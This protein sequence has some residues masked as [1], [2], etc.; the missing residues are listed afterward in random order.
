MMEIVRMMQCLERT[1]LVLVL[2]IIGV[3]LGA[4]ALGWR[5]G[6]LALLVG[7]L[8]LT[9]QRLSRGERVIN[10]SIDT[11]YQLLGG[12]SSNREN[13]SDPVGRLRDVLEEKVGAAEQMSVL[14][15]DLMMTTGTLVSGFTEALATADSQS[16]LASSSRNEIEAM[17]ECAQMTSSEA[18]M[19]AASSTDT[20]EQVR[21]GGG[22]V[23][24]VAS[25]MVN[26]STVA[27]AAAEEF[28]GLREQ[29][30][31]IEEIVAIIHNIA[32][33]T[34]LLA[35]NA[36]IEAAR[37]GEHG[38]GFSVVADEVRALAESTG[39]ATLSV[40][41]IIARIG[42]S[43]GRLNSALEQTLKGAA[44]GVTRTTQASAVLASIATASQQT[45][46]SVQGI[47]QRAES[48]MQSAGKVLEDSNAVARLAGELDSKVHTCNAG[49]RSLMMGLVEVKSLANLLEPNRNRRIALIEAIEETRAHNIMVLNSR[50]SRQMLPHIQRIRALDEEIDQLLIDDGRVLTEAGGQQQP[51]QL[52]QLRHAIDG[53]RQARDALLDAAQSGQLESRRAQIAPAVREAYHHVKHAFQNVFGSS[54]L[55]P[56]AG[57]L[58]ATDNTKTI[59]PPRLTTA[60]RAVEGAT[61]S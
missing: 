3:L 32:G 25:E 8:P 30:G 37:A 42:E 34:N 33:Q 17:A 24:Q 45:L 4:D 51:G 6:W 53:Y 9:M 41:E 47:A 43:I 50:D 36:A 35:L 57:Q 19:L 55:Q 26:L 49:L 21:T 58:I 20:Q 12:D 54:D 38:R 15:R 59:L 16:A 40:S 1:G 28:V 18:R 14:A 2:V 39:K 27:G 13:S 60:D 10:E 31:R 5:W 52:S 56:V 61:F 7:L 29:V 48:D 46:Q 22:Q 11:L 44:D 23:Q